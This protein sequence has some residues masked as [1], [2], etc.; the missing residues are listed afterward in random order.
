MSKTCLSKTS[1]S[2]FMQTDRTIP[3]GVK[4]KRCKSQSKNRILSFFALMP[5]HFFSHKISIVF[6][7]IFDIEIQ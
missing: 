2:E 1:N 3:Y 4:R 6:A 7:R 5:I